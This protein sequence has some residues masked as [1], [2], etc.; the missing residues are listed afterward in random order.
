[1]ARP[2]RNRAHAD[3]Q[4]CCAVP[5]FKIDDVAPHE[6]PGLSRFSGLSVRNFLLGNSQGSNGI[7]CRARLSIRT[8]DTRCGRPQ[9]FA[10]AVHPREKSASATPNSN[11]NGNNGYVR[12]TRPACHL[13]QIFFVL[14]TLTHRP[15][16]I[17]PANGFLAAD[18]TYRVPG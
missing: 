18:F 12:R 13:R 6:I 15:P 1:M 14:T 3:E 17:I 11:S 7:L 8:P 10:S 9:Y 5:A 16:S 2:G 4:Q